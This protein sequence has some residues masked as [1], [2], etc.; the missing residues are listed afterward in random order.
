METQFSNKQPL[1]GV[2]TDYLSNF[3][4][5]SRKNLTKLLPGKRNR[6]L[7]RGVQFVDCSL[8][9]VTNCILIFTVNKN[10]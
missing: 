6:S 1:N 9:T 8:I 3:E 10:T 2:S 5:V 7:I 4:K